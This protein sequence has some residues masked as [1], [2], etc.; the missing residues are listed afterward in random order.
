MALTGLLVGLIFGFALQRGRFCVTTAFRDMWQTKRS[1]YFTAFI[2]IIAIQAVGVAVLDATGVVHLTHKAL[3]WLAVAVGSLIFGVA[4]VLAAGCAT[5][6]WYRAG[7]GLVGSWIALVLYGASA[8]AMKYGPLAPLN[9]GLRSV[10]AP[11][12][13]IPT[14]FHISPWIVVAV[15]VI[16]AGYLVYRELTRPRRA[17]ATLPPTRTGLAHLLFEKPWHPLATALIIS[18]VAIVAY[19]LSFASGRQAGLGITTPSANLANWFATG[20]STRIDWGVWLVL[21]ILAGSSIAALAS[22]EFRVRVP[23]AG[24][25]IR[26]AIGGIGLGIGASLAGGCTIGNSMVETAQLAWQGWLAFGFTFLGVGLAVRYLQPR[27]ARSVPHTL[28]SAPAAPEPARV[29]VS[30]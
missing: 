19:P 20:D 1:S 13:T 7:E 5:G 30:A 21:G 11:A 9:D 10:T 28:T 26:S 2:A 18:A 3:P 27:A 14:T 6:T 22:G 25:A 17:V 29:P 23:D 16:V 15:L 12:T 8:A 4:M 24:T